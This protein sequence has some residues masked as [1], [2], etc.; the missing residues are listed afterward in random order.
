MNQARVLGGQTC[1]LFHGQN[2][3]AGRGE[4]VKFTAIG[5]YDE[6]H[7]GHINQGDTDVEDQ[8]DDVFTYCDRET[9]VCWVPDVGPMA[10]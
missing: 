4:E 3:Q 8:D 2:W 10:I 9:C 7:D 5:D 6:N 1:Y